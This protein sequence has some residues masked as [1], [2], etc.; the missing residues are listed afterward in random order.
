MASINGLSIRN[1]TTFQGHDDA[2]YYK[3]DLF[4]GE[5]MIG[6]WSEDPWCGPDHIDLFPQYSEQRLNDVLTRH[7]QDRIQKTE[8]E[9]GF[10]PSGYKIEHF[11]GDFILLRHEE[12][13][14]HEA[15]RDGYHAV[16]FLHIGSTHYRWDLDEEYAKM[17]NEEILRSLE[18][19][20]KDALNKHGGQRHKIR[21]YRSLEEFEQGLTI[22][23]AEIVFPS[24][25]R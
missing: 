6:K 23:S 19:D 17:P 11:A 2:T 4:L 8:Q 9:Y 12:Q 22:N 7:N 24:L 21:I 13:Y 1:L 25:Q 20:I 5:E 3:G 16:L 10:T 14:F 15:L 18:P